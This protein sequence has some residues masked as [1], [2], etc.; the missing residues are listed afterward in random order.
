[1]FR[2]EV[3]IQLSELY[4]RA[5]PFITN[6]SISKHLLSHELIEIIDLRDCNITYEI[7]ELLTKYF[8]RLT[9]L[10]LG[11]TENKL[12]GKITDEFFPLN[13]IQKEC[14]LR[15]PKLKYLTLEGIHNK[16][17]N[18]S[19][20]EVLYHSLIQSSEQ[21]RFV[22]LSRN[23]AIES[24]MYIDCFKQIHSLVLYDIL[25]SVI[26]SSIDS[27]C[28]LKTLILLDLSF[29]RR[30][31]EPQNY[32]KPTL[33]LAKL[34]RSLPKLM[35]LDISGTNLAGTY[36][37]DRDEELNYIRKELSIDDQE[38]SFKKKTYIE[39]VHL[40]SFRNFT[41]QSSIAGLLLLKHK[42]EFLGVFDVDERGSA[43]RWLPA[44]KV[45]FI[46]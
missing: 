3:L 38:Y 41:I 24:L 2:S 40:F 20:E 1:M 15:K 10:Y 21:V 32:S 22:D 46:I 44:K 18:D 8:P 6:K 37:F 13:S 11:R 25:P 43:R 19:I 30:I 12:E 23:S 9:A 39:K 36:S 28:S 4:F 35:S 5:C 7:F 33:T 26:E 27:I 31:Q 16:V 17:R 29:N 14:F 42:L 45:C 34:I